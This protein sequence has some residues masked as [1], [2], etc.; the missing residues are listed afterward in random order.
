MG[1]TANEDGKCGMAGLAQYT[2]GRRRCPR[3]Y[4]AT[5]VVRD[6]ATDIVARGPDDVAGFVGLLGR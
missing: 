3:S 2:S 4:A 6:A 5:Q 1:D